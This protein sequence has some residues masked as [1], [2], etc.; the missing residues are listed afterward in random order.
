MKLQQVKDD[1]EYQGIE[2]TQ[3]FSIKASV[4][5][6]EILSSGLYS[7]KILA[8]VRELSCNAYDSHV[9]NNNIATPF[10]IKLPN[11]FDPT[12]YVKDFGTGLPHE[13]VMSLYTTY[14]DSTK[15]DSN[16]FIGAL[17]L[18]SKSPFSCVSTFNVESRFGGV[19]TQYICFKN[20]IGVPSV[21]V[22][23][24]EETDEPTGMTVSLSTKYDD[25]SKWE[26][27]AKK[28]LMYF[29]VCPKVIGREEFTPYEVKHT[30]RGTSWKA[31]VSEYS[32]N[33]NGPYVVQGYVAYPI[34]VNILRNHPDISKTAKS[35][36]ELPIDMSVQLGDIEVAASR[37]ALSY[38]P[39]TIKNLLRELEKAAVELR[40]SIQQGFDDCKTEWEMCA[41]FDAI[42]NGPQLFCTIFDNFHFDKSF[43]WNNKIISP[44]LNINLPAINVKNFIIKRY[45]VSNK[46]LTFINSWD[47][48]RN[49]DKILNPTITKSLHVIVSKIA[50]PQN[51][52][53]KNHISTL[54]VERYENNSN[55]N[56]Y[57]LLIKPI[58][59][60]LYNQAELDRLIEAI[61]PPS[62]FLYEE[63]AVPSTKR[64]QAKKS[65]EDKYLWTGFTNKQTRWGVTN[66]LH[67]KFGRLCWTVET[68]DLEEGGFYVPIDYYD[69]IYPGIDTLYFHEIYKTAKILNLLPTDA[70]VYGIKEKEIASL[71]DK[72]INVFDHI[73]DEYKKF[74]KS[75][76]LDANVNIKAV[77]SRMN[78]KI[79]TNILN[80]WSRIGS[81]INDGEMKTFL[82]TI[83]NMLNIKPIVDLPTLNEFEN[84]MGYKLTIEKQSDTLIKQWDNLKYDTYPMLSLLDVHDSESKRQMIIDYINV[85]DR[86]C[87]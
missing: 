17:G 26:R 58:S 11:N 47:S 59:K 70:N 46:G 3:T 87:P 72:W 62:V 31:R 30:L 21:S 54:P 76:V 41:M 48:S 50:T 67:R 55:A 34:D 39:R 27:A 86:K 18:G 61:N 2:N 9:L 28:A 29:P 66:Q 13:D 35:L 52:E 71:N 85:V 79:F 80:N 22:A 82:T 77:T 33:M 75:G 15:S 49:I 57:V 63:I 60:K 20:E 36:L 4:Q 64:V 74:K 51:Q 14:F 44:N 68:I 84:H 53:I 38:T 43:L 25:I 32:A 73:K 45:L 65:K 42:K 5:A 6:F 23:H 10:E 19:K 8:I 24:R 40:E 69:I 78:N 1:I 16:D 7:D 81:T 12:F 56:K 37:E 83:H